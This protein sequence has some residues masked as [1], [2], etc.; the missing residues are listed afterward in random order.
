MADILNMTK[1]TAN[2]LIENNIEPHSVEINS[3]GGFKILKVDNIL[4]INL[5]PAPQ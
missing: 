5:P 3:D 1:E 2:H 4:P